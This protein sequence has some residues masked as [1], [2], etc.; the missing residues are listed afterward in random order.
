MEELL[1]IEA[2]KKLKYTYLR[3]VDTHDWALMRSTLTDDC[4]ARYDSGKYSFDGGDAVVEGISGFMNSP[5]MITQHQCHHPE[6]DL[7]GDTEARGKWYLQDLVF[8]FD[9][10]WLLF[11]TAIYSDE[12]RLEAGQWKKSMT[13]YE[14]IIETVTSPIPESMQLVHSMFDR[15]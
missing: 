9:E 12:Y 11:G 14:R 8:N 15:K 5:G 4:V 2:I 13:S 10:N 6:I 1:T 3:A 7:V